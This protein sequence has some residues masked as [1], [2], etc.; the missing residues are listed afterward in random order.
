MIKEVEQEAKDLVTWLTEETVCAAPDS[1]APPEM[2]KMCQLWSKVEQL[3]DMITAVKDRLRDL[4]A[5]TE[6]LYDE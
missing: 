5:V 3:L 2:C 6:D 1:C 4:A